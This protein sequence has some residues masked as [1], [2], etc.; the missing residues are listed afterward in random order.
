MPEPLAFRRLQLDGA[1]GAEPEPPVA[2][3]DGRTTR[4][5]RKPLGPRTW[6]TRADPFAG[7]WEELVAALTA[8]PERTAKDLL[9]ELQTRYPGQYTD[10]VLRTL[11]HRVKAWRASMILRFDTEWLE[12]DPLAGAIVP[13]LAAV[14]AGGTHG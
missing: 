9:R 12:N 2:A 14:A 5:Y 11:Q 4:R 8:R 7:V 13:P 1:T 6:R 3:R 10:S